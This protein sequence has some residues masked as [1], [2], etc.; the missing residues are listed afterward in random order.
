MR[1]T[2]FVF[3]LISTLFANFVQ[4]QFDALI[5]QGQT[6]KLYLSHTVTAGQTWYSIGR[7]YNIGPKALAAY[8]SLSMDKPLNTGV[9]IQIPLTSANFSQTGQKVAPG[10]TLAPGIHHPSRRERMDVP[11]QRQS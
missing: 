1:S 7:L 6:G 5:I 9:Q 11:H 2:A 10:E 4:A 3:L 8:N